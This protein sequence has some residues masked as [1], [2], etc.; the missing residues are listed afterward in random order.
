MALVVALAVAAFG[1]PVDD[2]LRAATTGAAASLRYA[3][4]GAVAPGQLADLACWDADHEG[5]FAWAFGL[6]ARRVWRGGRPAS[7]P[8]PDPA[9]PGARAGRLGAG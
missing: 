5:A 6:R 2:A 9:A 4:R 1:L 8:A 7:S 3:D